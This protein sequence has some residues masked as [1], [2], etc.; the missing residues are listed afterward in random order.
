MRGA[1][2]QLLVGN[3]LLVA[4]LVSR[5]RAAYFGGM[6]P[7]A[8]AGAK[9]HRPYVKHMLP[10]GRVVFR[11]LYSW[12]N[13]PL[14]PEMRISRWYIAAQTGRP[15]QPCLPRHFAGPCCSPPS[16]AHSLARP[17]SL[18]TPTFSRSPSSSASPHRRT[19]CCGLR[20]WSHA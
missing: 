4:F 11:P 14:P 7:L 15:L 6:H 9:A 12:R 20:I 1:L 3:G 13:N 17:S 16:R 19:V 2:V 18:S 8:G 5:T 10:G